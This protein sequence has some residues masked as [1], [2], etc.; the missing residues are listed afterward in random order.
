[1]NFA[2]R[3]SEFKTDISELP[4]EEITAPRRLP[5]SPNTFR[6][7]RSKTIS[8]NRTAFRR[9]NRQPRQRKLPANEDGKQNE[10]NNMH[11]LNKLILV[12]VV[13]A[14][15]FKAA[16]DYNIYIWASD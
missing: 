2:P 7:F 4:I 6:S 15:S 14:A 1:M 3:T 12:L 13:I 16:A 5:P 8:G 10:N 11:K 9:Q